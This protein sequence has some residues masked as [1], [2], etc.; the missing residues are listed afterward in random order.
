MVV[1]T[2]IMIG[3]LF[4]P[5]ALILS[6]ILPGWAMLSCCVLMGVAMAGIGFSVSHDALHGAYTDNPRI[7]TA[8]GMT[9]DLLGASSY[10][11]KIT[12][13]V[14]HHTYTNIHG[15]DEDLEV[16]PLLRLSPHAERR[17]W[18][19]FQHLYAPLAYSL[20]TLNWLFVKD[21]DYFSRRR[22]GPYLDKHHSPGAI[23][24]MLG[25]KLFSIFWMIVLPL[26]VL[27]VAWYWVILGF[28]VV[29][30]VGG[31]I[32][33]VIFQLAHV[34]EQTSYPVPDDIGDMPNGW[35]VHEMLTTANF[36]VDNRLLTWY[37]GGLNH[38]IEHHLF[39]KTCSVHYPSV[40]RI[41]RSTA[42]EHGIPY[43]LNATLASAVGNHLRML[44]RLGREEQPQ[45]ASS[46]AGV[47]L[48]RATQ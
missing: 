41:V 24:L 3:G 46:P 13:N 21:F 27:P 14:I 11:W 8:I 20:S 26:L 34:V 22:L 4:G 35:L 30:L 43:H 19:R 15:V 45:S 40:S 16:S 28:L 23:A 36:C 38:Q 32:L 7:N 31:F 12:H 18:Q 39:P 1:K 2:V 9:F 44:K 6:G 48:V 5:Y 33:G 29:H 37:V 47:P 42:E 10:M 25:S 17:P